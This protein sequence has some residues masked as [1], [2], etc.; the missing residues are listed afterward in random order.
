RPILGLPSDKLAEIVFGI[1]EEAIIVP[2][3]AWTPHF[4]VFGSESGFDS[5]EECFGRWTDKIFA[6]ETGLSSSPDMNW[7]I[8]QLDNI[9]LI[10]NS[11]SHSLP[12]IG[13]EANVFDTE[14]SFNAIWE[15][16]REKDPKKFLFTIEFFPEEGKY[17]YDGHRN[18]SV[19]F[20]PKETIENKGI[21]PVCSGRVTVGV[22][23]RVEKLADRPE[24]FTP[25]R[26]IPYKNMVPFDQIIADAMNIAE[27]SVKVKAEYQKLIS[28]LGNEIR[29]LLKT[30][31]EDIARVSGAKIADGVK[32]VR[33]GKLKIIPGYDGEYG[34]VKIFSG[35]IVEDDKAQAT[36]F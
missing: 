2:A 18:C 8:S 1:S 29:I 15:A 25:S 28:A 21:C 20:T 24:G 33:E 36:L 34:H 16:V 9:S 4:S 5:L 31:I 30:P 23:S 6:I 7:R 3:H 19:S 26:H 11:D 13:R 12:R 27:T 14:L 17:H 35:E 10:S 32:R 22:L